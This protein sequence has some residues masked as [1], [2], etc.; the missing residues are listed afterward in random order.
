[1]GDDAAVEVAAIVPR[2]VPGLA[3]A[4]RVGGPDLDVVAAGVRFP[5]EDPAHPGPR[6]VRITEHGRAE[7][8]PAVHAHVHALDAGIGGPRTAAQQYPLRRQTRGSG[9][10]E[11]ALADLLLDR[12]PA[13]RAGPGVPGPAKHAPVGA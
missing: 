8:A 13:R 11:R 10:L 7:A 4:A 12:D 3:D 2:N 1:M 9:E 5:L 6:E